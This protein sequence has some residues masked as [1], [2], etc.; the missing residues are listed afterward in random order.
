V[1]QS[2]Q[3]AG[4]YWAGLLS[5]ILGILKLTVATHWS[6]SR[7]LVPVWAVLGHNILYI[8]LGFIWLSFADDGVIEEEIVLRE[9]N[10]TY[11]YQLTALVSFVMFADN[12]LTRIEGAGQ[13]ARFVLTS[14]RWELIIVFGVL[15]IALQVLFWS[16]VVPIV[17]HRSRRR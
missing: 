14:G 11:C 5:V 15:S 2:I 4:F 12:M 13:M 16:E 17:R 3:P 1:R 9:S 6:W 8:G 10:R 7:V